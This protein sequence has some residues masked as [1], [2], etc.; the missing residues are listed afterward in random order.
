MFKN[1]KEIQKFIKENNVKYIDFK[2]V[3]LKGRFR[4]L[5][6]PADR[7]S[8]K[9]MTDGIGFDASNYGYAKVEKS[10]MVFIPDLAT[11]VVDP[12]SEIKTITMMANVYVIN[13]KKNTPFD[14]YPRNVVRAA[15]DYMKSSKVADE[16]IIG[17]EYEFHVFDSMQ[18]KLDPNNISMKLY[19]SES[20]WSS[21]EEMSDGFHT[22]SKGGY[23]IDKPCDYT[24]DLR[25][26]ICEYMK[27]YGI[28]V[29]Y[30]HHEVGGSGQL[31]IEVE[32]ADMAKL[33]DDTMMA[34][35]IIKNTAVEFG[36][37]ATLM[38]KPIYGEAGN[39]MHVHMLLKKNGKSIFY[40]KGNYA[41]LSDEAMYFIGGILKHIKSLCAFTNPTTNS[42]K[43][44]VPGFEAPVT[45]GYAC[46]NRSSVIR[47]PTYAKQEDTRFELRNPDAMCNPYFAYSAIL[48]AGL[49]GIKNKI[50]PKDYNW[51]PFD[52]NLFDLSDKEKAK[53][54]QL[55][56][57]LD[58][59]IE[60][61]KKDHDYLL[62]NDVFT[63]D[64][65]DRWVK[66]IKKDAD[67]VN[68]MPHP[69]EFAAYYDL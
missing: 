29:K 7:L 12:F 55:P 52:F 43:R 14:Q 38:P 30:H 56:T 10:D 3:D 53:L 1:I 16:M 26:Q 69:A 31:E 2:L 44:L 60:C 39:G 67:K 25:N 15:L 49:D 19:S 9:T 65:I 28:N 21:D 32:L 27:D 23:H 62:V 57:S 63:E 46:A 68:K 17:P 47:I 54:S 66:E 4:H 48:M 33:A 34:K 64:L 58:D 22:P 24:F 45:I 11:A 59:A 18:Y 51:G 37:S 50:N 42:Y 5:A 61:L 6:I 13:D 8:E 35:Y 40:K 36:M 20:E 41:N